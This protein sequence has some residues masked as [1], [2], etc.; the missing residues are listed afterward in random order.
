MHSLLPQV[1]SGLNDPR[2]GGG[3][4]HWFASSG[5]I[6]SIPASGSR[7]CWHSN[8][9][10][11][12]ALLDPGRASA[13]GVVVPAEEAS[14]WSRARRQDDPAANEPTW[15]RR[16]FARLPESVNRGIVAQTLHEIEAVIRPDGEDPPAFL[17]PALVAAA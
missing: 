13:S 17:D 6:L 16:V 9:T 11:T 10:S 8:G 2:N 5:V 12:V 14:T 4:T 1:S 15:F 7:N 3:S